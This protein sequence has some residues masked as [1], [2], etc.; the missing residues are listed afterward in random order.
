MD[1]TLR[2]RAFL[3]LQ[4]PY[5]AQIVQVAVATRQISLFHPL[6][7]LCATVGRFAIFGHI[8]VIWSFV[9]IFTTNFLVTRQVHLFIAACFLPFLTVK[10]AKAVLL[11]KNV[12][13]MLPRGV[14]RGP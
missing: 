8:V 14:D 3:A 12:S 2:P 5:F 11:L 13:A 6:P 10:P 9:R 4:R 7:V 1:F